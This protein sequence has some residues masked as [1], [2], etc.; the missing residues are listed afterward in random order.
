MYN[1]VKRYQNIILK[2]LNKHLLYFTCDTKPEL[3][4]SGSLLLASQNVIQ[5]PP[6]TPQTPQLEFVVIEDDGVWSL[7]ALHERD[8]DP[9]ALLN[10]FF[11]VIFLIRIVPRCIAKITGDVFLHLWTDKKISCRT[12]NGN[13]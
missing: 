11:F 13:G 7:S 8:T 3:A 10:N 2:K 6:R 9:P 1:I 4:A 5:F 12:N